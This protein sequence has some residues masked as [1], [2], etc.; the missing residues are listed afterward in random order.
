MGWRGRVC[1]KD[2]RC[3]DTKSTSIDNQDSQEVQ[4]VKVEQL[5]EF[6]DS[7]IYFVG[8]HLQLSNVTRTELLNSSEQTPRVTLI[9]LTN[10]IVLDLITFQEKEDLPLSWICAAAHYLSGVTL[11]YES[12]KKKFVFDWNFD[13]KSDNGRIWPVNSDEKYDT[14]KKKHVLYKELYCW[15]LLSQY[16]LSMWLYLC[17][18]SHKYL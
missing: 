13:M 9:D 18:Y 15:T 2:H 11:D 10:G 17:I 12:L 7:N 1:I 8:E 3:T 6:L 4:S 16:L 5:K 14:M